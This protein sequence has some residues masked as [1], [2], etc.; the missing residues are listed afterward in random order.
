MSLK[1]PKMNMNTLII[2][3]INIA[4]L[5]LKYQFGYPNISLLSS[6]SSSINNNINIEN[7]INK[8]NMMMMNASVASYP[9][10]LHA[11]S[12]SHSQESSSQTI[13]FD[14][15]RGNNNNRKKNKKIIDDG[16]I[17]SL[18]C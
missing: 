16:I 17:Y 3:R 7:I 6:S 8:N 11:G 2:I 18:T 13:K 14:E 9:P 4:M 5:I 12:L 15:F 10:D 1:H